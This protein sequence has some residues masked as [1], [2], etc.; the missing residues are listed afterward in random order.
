MD[1][2]QVEALLE[3]VGAL[4]A[5]HHEAGGAHRLRRFE[6][7]DPLGD[8]V[9]A[10]QLGR[11][12]AERLAPGAHDLVAV[13]DGIDTSVLGYVVG[14]ALERSVVRI[15]DHEGL[16]TASAPI[17]AGA[18]A[19]FVAPAILDPQQPRLARALMETRDA[20]LAS[21]AALVDVGDPGERPIA[22]VRLDSFSPDECPACRRGEPLANARVSLAP[23]GRN[24]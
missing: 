7:F 2:A 5:V 21:V 22:L 1:E 19:V 24:G 9:A 18:R 10:E 20:T 6:R 3:R 4:A 16:I 11:A 12:L 14:R 13:W 8:P 15:Y 23:G 17:P